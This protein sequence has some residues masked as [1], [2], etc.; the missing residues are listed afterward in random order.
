[1]KA[2]LSG[3]NLHC[4]RLGDVNFLGVELSK[5]RL[6]NIEWGAS[7]KQEIEALK[8]RSARDSAKEIALYQELEEVCRNIRK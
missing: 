7:F 5:T 4:A 1:M 2:N 6:E 3:A 8:A